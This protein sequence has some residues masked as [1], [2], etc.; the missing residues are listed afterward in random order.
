MAEKL[1]TIPV[2][3]AFDKNSECPIC[4][5]YKKLEDDSI[6][7]MMGPS[8]MEDDIRMETDKLGFCTPHMRMLAVQKNRLGLA[9]IL[10]THLDRQYREASEL[11]A[12]PM[13]ASSFLKKAEENAL[14]AW[15]KEKV[16]S[17]YV[18]RRIAITFPHY[19]DTTIQ[20]YK[21]DAAFREKYKNSRGFCQEHFGL[22]LSEGQRILKDQEFQEFKDTTIALYLDNIKRLSEELDW[23]TD[24]FDYRYK[25]APWKNSRDA[26]ER[27]VVK[28][29][30]I[31][32]PET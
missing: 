26:I 18:C 11:K 16:A 2:N 19:I 22:L 24:K 7:F 17:C 32:P 13:K 31:L 28:T 20:L 8:Y 9:L 10:K 21:K 23:F 3:D 14:S 27:A 15:A 12:K 1:Y 25:D 5:M 30:G 4:S 6:D 29:N